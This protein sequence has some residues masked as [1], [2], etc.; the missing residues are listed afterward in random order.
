[1][2]PIVCPHKLGLYKELVEYYF[3]KQ[4]MGFRCIVSQDKY[5]LVYM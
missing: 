3:S 5:K 4:E 2:Q 1:M